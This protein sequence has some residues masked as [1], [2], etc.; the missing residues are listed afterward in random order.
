MTDE[1]SVK[2]S[3]FGWR[4]LKNRVATKD[5]LLHMG[6]LYGWEEVGCVFYSNEL[7]TLDLMFNFQFSKL[8]WVKIST[9]L[10]IVWCTETL[11][12]A[13]LLKFM[14]SMKGK[15]KRGRILLFWKATCQVLWIARNDFIFKDGVFGVIPVVQKVIMLTWY[16]YSLGSKHKTCRDFYF[17]FKN[18]FDFV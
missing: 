1:G 5:Q 10:G 11:L 4:C 12:V 8:V 16:W 2:V 17:Q 14:V 9:W 13:H 7:E 18:L 15:A 6:F 3:I